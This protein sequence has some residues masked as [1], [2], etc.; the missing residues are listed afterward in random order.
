VAILTAYPPT[1][2]GLANYGRNLAEAYS[3]AVEDVRVIASDER[4]PNNGDKGLDSANESANERPDI[5]VDR[6]WRKDDPR[7]L[8]NIL[9]TLRADRDRFDLLHFNLKPT[10]YGSNNL[11]RFCSL[12]VP[13]AAR[14]FLDTEIVVTMHDIFETVDHEKID[15]D[16]GILEQVGATAATAA[17]LLA[18]PV[19]VTNDRHRTMLEDKYPMGDVTV[20]PHG[21]PRTTARGSTDLQTDPFRILLF[22]YVSPYKDYAGVLKAFRELREVRPDAELHVAGGRHPSQPE[23]YDDIKENCETIDGATFHGYIP[24]D[25]VEAFF[26]DSSVLVLPYETAPG[27]SGPFQVAKA[28]GLPV[29]IYDNPDVVEATVGTGGDAFRVEPGDSEMLAECLTSIA[30]DTSELED[31]SRR[32]RNGDDTTMSEVTRRI[33]SIASDTNE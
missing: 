19:T 22:G 1:N 29:V 12:F 10:Y 21:V 18:A 9:R 6:V 25:R 28:T 14:G 30:V 7:G 4:S 13:L 17:V 3:E 2:D 26:A 5:D 15:E 33:R 27:V 32:N 16:V 11:L 24:E 31:M 8:L 23:L 20:V